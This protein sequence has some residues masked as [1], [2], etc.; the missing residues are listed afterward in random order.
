MD[1]GHMITIRLLNDLSCWC[2]AK[3]NYDRFVFVVDVLVVLPL[4]VVGIAGNT[5]AV[6]VLNYDT[7]VNYATTLLLSAIAVVDDVYLLSCLVYQT[8]KA[9]C[10][11]TD[12]MLGLRSIY[13]QASFVFRQEKSYTLCSEKNTHS[14]FLSNLHELSVDLNKN[15]SEY[16]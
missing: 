5:L 7:S 6:I 3:S 9:L 15:C 10:Y 8:G 2:L 11:R 4:S 1:V 14:H 16:T 13:P 12:L